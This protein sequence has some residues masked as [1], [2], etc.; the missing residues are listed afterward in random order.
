M[1]VSEF[2]D[3]NK[4]NYDKT[5]FLNLLKE[6]NIET[7]KKF[8]QNFIW[9]LNLLQKFIDKAGID[10]NYKILEIGAGAGTLSY[11]LSNNANRVLSVEID[12]NLEALLNDIAE[13]AKTDGKYLDFIFADANELDWQ[14]IYSVDNSDKLALVSNLPYNLTSTL[15]AKAIREFY[16][17]DKMLLLV[18]DNAAPRI[19]G[20]A[21]DG[22]SEN[23]NQG[24]LNK[25]ISIYGNSKSLL[26]VSKNNFYPAP[27][28]NSELILLEANKE[29]YSYKIL[30]KYSQELHNLL[31]LAF[32]QRRKS[33]SNCL[34][35]H[36]PKEIVKAWVNRKNL[37]TNIR[38]EE[39]SA[40]DF[41]ELLEFLISKG[42]NLTNI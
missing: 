21:G 20:K 1:H 8:G 36:V 38:A 34:E 31:K 11:V 30:R 3:L 9:N 41:A 42:I 24:F 10:E 4:G 19:L 25:L 6:Y 5:S 14:E 32:S 29:S 13:Q 23:T 17:A 7:N 35:T 2:Y 18:E 27:R 12:R 33:L 26:K 15:I 28:I 39:I 16:H 40:D 37:K 22:K